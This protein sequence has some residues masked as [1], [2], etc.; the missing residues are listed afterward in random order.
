MVRWLALYKCSMLENDSFIVLIVRLLRLASL[1][2][3]E[4]ILGC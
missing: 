4:H 2:Q 3:R 1:Q